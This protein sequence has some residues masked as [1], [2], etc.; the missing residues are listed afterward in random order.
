MGSWKVL[1]SFSLIVVVQHVN[2]LSSAE[3]R[4]ADQMGDSGAS[5]LPFSVPN[6]ALLTGRV[7]SVASLPPLD[8]ESGKGNGKTELRKEQVRGRKDHRLQRLKLSEQLK[9]SALPVIHKV[10]FQSL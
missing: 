1:F 8:G 9:S 3:G 2:P 10:A 4:P 7:P 6:G 5:T